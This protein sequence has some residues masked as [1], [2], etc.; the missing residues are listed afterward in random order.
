MMAYIPKLKN[1]KQILPNHWVVKELPQKLGYAK[2][3]TM[4]YIFSEQSLANKLK[5]LYSW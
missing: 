5:F 3:I 1:I 2:N 4:R